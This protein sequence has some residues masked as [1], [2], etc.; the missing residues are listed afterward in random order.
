M[1]TVVSHRGD[2][3]QVAVGR[4]G[5]VEHL[6]AVE[7]GVDDRGVGDA[8]DGGRLGGGPGPDGLDEGVGLELGGRRAGV[9]VG[10]DRGVARRPG[11]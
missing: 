3:E 7:R 11:R 4:A 10:H 5:G 1:V 6:D 9:A 8:G 2:R